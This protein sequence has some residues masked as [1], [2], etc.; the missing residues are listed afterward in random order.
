M[1]SRRKQGPG[2]QHVPTPCQLTDITSCSWA[3]LRAWPRSFQRSVISVNPAKEQEH[4][5]LSQSTENLIL[6]LC[7]RRGPLVHSVSLKGLQICWCCADVRGA[8]SQHPTNLVN[9]W[10]WSNSVQNNGRNPNIGYCWHGSCLFC[11]CSI[12]QVKLTR[13]LPNE[14]L[15]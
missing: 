2:F 3:S 1:N 8:Q 14:A 7:G 6:W 12:K 13:N 10:S 15:F 5:V 4:C 9:K 11:S